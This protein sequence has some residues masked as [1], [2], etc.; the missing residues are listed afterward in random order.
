MQFLVIMFPKQLIGTMHML[1]IS[2]G[3]RLNVL[4]RFQ[5][6]KYVTI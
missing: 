6:H 3:L 1:P 5:I 4:F 2:I